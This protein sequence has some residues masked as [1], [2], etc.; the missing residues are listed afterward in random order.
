[1]AIS[2]YYVPLYMWGNCLHEH[3]VATLAF[4]DSKAE[5]HVTY[6]AQIGGSLRYF[7]CL[8]V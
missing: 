5:K 6:S 1:M 3:I 2:H 7:I 4:A 8:L